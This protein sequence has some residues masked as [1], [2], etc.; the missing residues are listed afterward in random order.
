MAN[1]LYEI[2]FRI[3]GKIAASF[4]KS[5]TTAAGQLDQVSKKISQ[6]E[7]AQ[8]QVTRFRAL[9]NE[10]DE[11]K[12]RL[13]AAEAEAR[14]LGST[15]GPMTAD[16][17]RKFEA[18]KGKAEKLRLEFR[19]QASELKNVK[20]AMEAAGVA[21]RSMAADSA[22]LASQLQKTQNQQ[23]RM[24]LSMA[25]TQANQ[26]ARETA[27]AKYG[28]SKGKMLGAAAGIAAVILP[29]VVAAKFEDS[30]VRAGALAHATDQ[31][32]AAM[33]AQARQLGRDT[34]FSAVQAAE[35]M[36][37]LSMSGFKAAETM[38]AMPG[39]LDI[40][41][42]GMVTVGEAADI[43]SNILRG[44]GMDADKAGRL[45]DVLTN[46]FTNSNTTLAMLGDTMKYVAPV[47]KAT[48][49]SL[50]KTAA[51]A[52]VL[53]NA[54]IKGEM[55]GTAMRAMLSRLAAPPRMAR[56]A[57]DSLRVKTKDA[58]G[59]M[60][61]LDQI[62][63]KINQKMA[64]MGTGT[65]QGLVTKIFGME[66]ASAATV[67][68][69][70]QASGALAQMTE[71]V[72]KS[73]SAAEIAAKQAKTMA[74]QWD[75]LKGSLEDTNIGVGNRL[76]PTLK[77]LVDT[78]VPIINNVTEWAEA[79]PQLTTALVLSAASLATLNL[80][81]TLGSTAV[82]AVR[83]GYLAAATAV[84]KFSAANRAA[85][86]ASIVGFMTSVAWI[87]L[88]AAGIAGLVL[89]GY[90][91]KKEWTAIQDWWD[92]LWDDMFNSIADVVNQ[93]TPLLRAVGIDIKDMQKGAFFQNSRYHARFAEQTYGKWTQ[94]FQG[95]NPDAVPTW[96]QKGSGEK[97]FKK[98]AEWWGSGSD[99]KP[100]YKPGF[101]GD[102]DQWL[103]KAGLLGTVG[104][105]DWAEKLDKPSAGDTINF[106]P[107]INLPPGAPKETEDAAGRALTTS[108][109]EFK[110]MMD[111]YMRG[112]ARV[113]FGH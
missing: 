67:L 107:T 96:L 19:E 100:G 113:S 62:L 109:R 1:R 64:K 34:R 70:G 27:K 7:Q 48:G 46:T 93:I 79:H 22:K 2:A 74:G 49:L 76:I 63:S 13:A 39:M 29:A 65:K 95:Y 83:L 87:A 78:F 41:G 32:M 92:K 72:G 8:G 51:G 82:A 61:P 15:M 54:G 18:A 73:G 25:A 97:R 17:A 5:L 30:M 6:L 58:A 103:D 24:Q 111:Q 3:G 59:N 12:K 50:E 101:M 14:H 106:S 75:N 66:A 38:A 42:A 89:I 68:L 88:V 71:T 102:L 112:Q 94:N 47:A 108:Q 80:A 35:G 84:L 33:T 36:Q 77:S 37:F 86:M 23:K 52:G 16:M 57:L 55:A 69:A 26:K 40:A 105:T 98:Q 56:D 44:F 85:T 60:L 91:L 10:I 45:G 81:M 4:P 31:Q 104:L 21:Q 110:A 20:A 11:T 90:Q 28:E 9:K 43:T 53:A 99:E